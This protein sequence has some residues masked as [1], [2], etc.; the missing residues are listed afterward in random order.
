[1]SFTPDFVV[2]LGDKEDDYMQHNQ[3]MMQMKEK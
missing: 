3:D 1:M 2:S